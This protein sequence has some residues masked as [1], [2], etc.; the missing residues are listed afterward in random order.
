MSFVNNFIETGL[1]ADF[2]RMDD[3][4]KDIPYKIIKFNIKTTQYGRGLE[5]EIEDPKTLEPFTI[6][7]PDRLAKKVTKDEELEDLNQQN[8]SFIFKGRENRA[9]ILEFFKA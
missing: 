3:L 9:A 7:F 1:G 6:F 4:Q 2:R 5:G 8:F